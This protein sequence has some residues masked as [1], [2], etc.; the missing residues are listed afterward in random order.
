MDVETMQY[1]HSAGSAGSAILMDAGC[2]LD[3]P[4]SVVFDTLL[5]PYDLAKEKEENPLLEGESQKE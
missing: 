4:F 3:L 2:V 1:A 5:V